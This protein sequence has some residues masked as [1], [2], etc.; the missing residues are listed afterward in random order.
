MMTSTAV[1]E[2]EVAELQ[3]APPVAVA[4]PVETVRVES[5]RLGAFE[6][7]RDKVF[8][9]ERGLVGLPSA[10]RFVVVDHRPGSPFRWLLCLDD[11]ELAFVVADPVELV[12]GYAP[13][14][15]EAASALRCA[16]EDVAVMVLVTIPRDPREVSVNLLAPVVVDLSRRSGCQLVLEGS[17]LDPAHRL[18]RPQP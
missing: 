16:P 9:L 12:P 1:R 2:V 6:V 4:P 7:P 13:P 10:R 3:I 5:N 17:R 11:P 18:A 8:V 15:A 14:L